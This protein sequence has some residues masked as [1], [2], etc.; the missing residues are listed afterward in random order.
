MRS[1]A[2][3]VFATL[4]ASGMADASQRISIAVAEGVYALQPGAE[5]AGEDSAADRPALA[6][7][8]FIVGP[9]GVVVVDTGISFRDGEDIIAAVRHVTRQPIRMAILTHPSQEAI[10]GAAAFQARGIPVLMHRDAAAL[11]AGRCEACLRNLKASL[12]DDAMAAT[13]VVVPDRL[14]GGDETLDAIGRRLRV[15]APPRSSAPGALAVLDERTSTLIAGSIVTLHSVPDTRDGDP[16][17]WRDALA[18]LAATR[19]RRL[20]GSFGAVGRCADIDSFARYFNDL[21]ARVADLLRQGVGLGELDERCGLPEYERWDRY[22]LLHPG[23]AS[24]EYLR[25][26]RAMFDRISNLETRPPFPF[27]SGRLWWRNDP[28]GDEPWTF[29]QR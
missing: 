26:E 23:N 27:Q 29:V 18:T 20:V 7:A 2:S 6:R 13:R 8:V 24:R 21:Q 3:L 1:A 14:I 11:M 16:R 17:G 10:F 25:Q 15:I 5:I 28:G 22:D 4:L 12:G 9:R 19:C